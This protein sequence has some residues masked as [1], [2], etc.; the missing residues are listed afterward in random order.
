MKKNGNHERW[1][2]QKDITAALNFR[3]ILIFFMEHGYRPLWNYN[4]IASFEKAVNV[5]EETET[6][7]STRTGHT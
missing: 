4:K 1:A 5:S 7:E 6:T 2:M 3:R